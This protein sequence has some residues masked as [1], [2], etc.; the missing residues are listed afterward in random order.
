[1]EPTAWVWEKPIFHNQPMALYADGTDWKTAQLLAQQTGINTHRLL[2][3][4]LDKLC[5][6]PPPLRVT[7]T[8]GGWQENRST[9]LTF[10]SLSLR[11]FE[12]AD[13]K[14]LYAVCVKVRNLRALADVRQHC[15]H[16]LL[17]GQSMAG[18]RWRVL[19]KLPVPKRCDALSTHPRPLP[20]SPSLR[21]Q[22]LCVCGQCYLTSGALEAILAFDGC[23]ELAGRQGLNSEPHEDE[24]GAQK[25]GLGTHA[26]S[27]VPVRMG[28]AFINR[29]FKTQ[30]CSGLIFSRDTE[31]SSASGEGKREAEVVGGGCG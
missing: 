16:D 5:E 13:G 23:E 10:S 7:A 25:S 21:L 12:D 4:F 8:D 2:R 24:G 30:L 9:L 26:P 11:L 1:M 14:A 27:P 28:H 6:M 18:Y 20:L 3:Q 22:S 19:Y 31:D 29:E 17:R 15:W